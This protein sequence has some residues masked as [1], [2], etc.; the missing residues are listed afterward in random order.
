MMKKERIDIWEAGEYSYP[1][2]YGFVPNIRTYI[3]DDEEVRDAMLV[4]PGGGYCMVVPSEA[5]IV[6][7]EFYDRGMNTFVLTY[8]TDI[9]M[10]VPLKKQP[11][12]DI[13]RAMRVLRADAKC[14]LVNPDRL[15]ICGFSAGAHVCGSL[16]THFADVK[17]DNEKYAG[18]N[19]RPT[20]A[21]LSYPVITTGEKTHIY[22]V[23][24]LLGQDAPKEE[25]EYFSLEKNV[26]PDT[27]PCFIWQTAGDGLVPVENSYMFAESLKAAGVPYAHYVFP[28]GDHGLSIASE[29]FFRGNH[30]EDYTFEQLNLTLP[31]IKDHTLINVSEERYKELNDQ[32]FGDNQ[33]VAPPM[34]DLNPFPDVR[35][36]PELADI[37]M[38]KL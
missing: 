35:M 19:N 27:P 13:S 25:M 31:H 30:G 28:N 14:L 26:T 10:G 36:W 3:H 18:V 12:M 11:L 20:G 21:I 6:A 1:A 7:K 4:V 34:T 33:Y 23:W 15:F 38:K 16:C 32:F 8:T 29:D 22:S 24:A 37:W 2:S 5:E 9:T 17:D